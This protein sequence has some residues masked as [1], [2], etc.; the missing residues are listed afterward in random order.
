MQLQLK[1]GSVQTT[2]K[3]R[4]H[5][6]A[7]WAANLLAQSWQQPLN[8]PVDMIGSMA[9]IA[10]PEMSLS[11]VELGDR[12][13]QEYRIEVPIMPFADRLWLRVSA[14]AYNQESEYQLNCSS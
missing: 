4:N 13:W 2:V 10:L 5:D 12:L 8:A 9:T 1:L 11:A 7:V 14:Q 6:L 3:Q